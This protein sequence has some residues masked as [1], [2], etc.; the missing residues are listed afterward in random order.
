MIGIIWGRVVI[1]G[2]ETIFQIQ[3]RAAR[4]A[5]LKYFA[6]RVLNPVLKH[7]DRRVVILN[8]RERVACYRRKSRE[9]VIGNRKGI[10]RVEVIG[11]HILRAD[12]C[13][14]IRLRLVSGGN[15]CVEGKPCRENMR[16]RQSEV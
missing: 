15:G 6:K 5:K 16:E 13:F 7:S 2:F 4:P 8:A 9:P 1:Y 10:G 14:E 3:I 12:I 11:A